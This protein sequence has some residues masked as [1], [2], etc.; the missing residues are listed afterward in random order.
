MPWVA[1][2]NKDHVLE[3][4]EVVDTHAADGEFRIA[5]PDDCDL[6]PQKYRWRHDLKRFVP[7]DDPDE[8]HKHDAAIY[9]A[10]VILAAIQN[11]T[12]GR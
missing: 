7:V 3:G 1:L 4:F 8:V 11:Y 9:R 10:E 6:I 2:L 12:A 5:V